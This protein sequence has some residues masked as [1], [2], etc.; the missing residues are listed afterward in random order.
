MNRITM[1]KSLIIVALLCAVVFS[2]TIFSGCV[3]WKNPEPAELEPVKYVYV[4]DGDTIG[5]T[6]M[7]G[8]SFTVRL[9][10]I[11]APE[12]VAPESY[13]EKTGKENSEYGEKASE[14]LTLMLKDCDLLYLEYDEERKDSY[15]RILA[16]VHLTNQADITNTANYKMLQDG[17]AVTME[18]VPNVKYCKDLKA[19]EEDAENASRGLW[20]YGNFMNA[21]AGK[22]SP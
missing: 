18:I 19:A 1:K 7:D 4:K 3:I 2:I 20:Q 15:D 9:I 22:T 6:G 8:G 10:G 21:V 12:S 14:H 17:Y 16:Y 11:D 13:T 5:V